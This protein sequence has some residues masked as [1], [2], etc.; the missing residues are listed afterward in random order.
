[1]SR[2]CRWG[3]GVSALAISVFLSGAIVAQT[4][5]N[6][7]QVVA[8]ASSSSESLG[9]NPGVQYA[10][11]IGIANYSS[12]PKLGTPVSDAKEVEQVLRESYGFKT[13]LLVD[14]TRDQI[15]VALDN[16]RR[17]LTPDDSLMIYYAGHGFYDKLEDQAYWAPVDAGQD[18]YA[19]WIIATELTSRAKAIAARHVLI[20]SD[21][22]Y[23]GK[24]ARDVAIKDRAADVRGPFLTRM[25]EDKSRD[26]MSSGG[27]E[28]VSDSDT[29]GHGDHSVF[30]NALLRGLKQ[31]EFR[32]FAASELFDQYVKIQVPG[33]SRQMPE[34]TP[35]RDSG[36]EGGDFVF[37]CK[38]KGIVVPAGGRE[39]IPPVASRID[40]EQDA[41]HD[42][43]SR[44]Q[45]SYASMDT[46]LLRKVWP[47]L[48]RSQI[49]ELRAGFD[50]A[51]AVMVELRNSKVT[52]SGNN[53][54]VL[55]DQWMKWTRA[56][57]Q[58]PPQVN[59]VEI[60][61]NKGPDGDW[62]IDAVSGR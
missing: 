8:A 24:L 54:T 23:S 51:K 30:A 6:E 25:S 36:H 19:H 49:K 40:P 58:Q 17:T 26:L 57:H 46:D 39:D 14:A 3:S 18:T 7:R 55:S 42:A 9:Q 15:L 59:P 27:D 4:K 21:S 47:S 22:C 2:I 28:P 33:R 37:F 5:T 10:L 32:E 11:V 16:A 12:L 60:R 35:I 13:Q 29:Q 44:Y 53:A 31:M 62:M 61:L 43:L 56:S 34:Y 41:V 48:S 52:V 20:I 45:E 1:M 38:G 50:G